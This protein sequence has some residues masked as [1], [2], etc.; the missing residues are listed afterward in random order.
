[1]LGAMDVQV[2]TVSF[3]TDGADA[4]VSFR[5]KGSTDGGL[6]MNY[7][8]ELKNGKWVVKP[9]PQAPGAPHGGAVPPV[10]GSGAMPPGHP[11]LPNQPVH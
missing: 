6:D 3:R 1:M 8:L 5:P 4:I 10:G 11:A 9:K 7:E 2:K